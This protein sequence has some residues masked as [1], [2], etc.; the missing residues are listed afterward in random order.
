MT[1]L[2][3][4]GQT[5]LEETHSQG[6]GMPLMMMLQ[7]YNHDVYCFIGFNPLLNVTRVDITQPCISYYNVISHLVCSLWVS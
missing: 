6:H 2:S 5:L 3:S 1:Q 7:C 4:S